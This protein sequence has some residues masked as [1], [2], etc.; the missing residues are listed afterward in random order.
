MAETIQN[1]TNC[2]REEAEAALKEHKEVWRAVD[3]LMI[4]PPVAGDTYIP[5]APEIDRG[6]SQEQL[7]RCVKGRWL[8]AQVN[9]VFSVAQSK[10]LPDLPAV[11]DA[12]ARAQSAEIPTAP[13]QSQPSS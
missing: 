11:Q 1:L 5:A 3:A 8:Q 13:V 6:I 12:G 4:R 10:T 2:T 9:A 7:D